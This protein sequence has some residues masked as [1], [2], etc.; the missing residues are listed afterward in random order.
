MLGIP[1]NTMTNIVFISI[2]E[3]IIATCEVALN[4]VLIRNMQTLVNEL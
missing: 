3:I 2:S 1:L 4:C